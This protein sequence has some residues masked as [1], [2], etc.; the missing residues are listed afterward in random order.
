MEVLVILGHI[1]IFNSQ[2]SSCLKIQSSVTKSIAQARIGELPAG[3]GMHEFQL[4]QLLRHQQA[5]PRFRNVQ[6]QSSVVP[7]IC[8]GIYC[9]KYYGGVGGGMADG[10]K[11]KTE[12][13]GGGEKRKGK[14]ENEKRLKKKSL[15]CI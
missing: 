5:H 2:S 1:R 10:K 9:A 15:K 3:G 6:G 8:R 13:L 14:R 11:I 4:R 12:G 7:D